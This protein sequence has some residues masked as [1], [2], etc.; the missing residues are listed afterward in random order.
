MA[1][2]ALR[3]KRR[4]ARADI[5]TVELPMLFRANFA[6]AEIEVLAASLENSLLAR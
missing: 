6:R 1:E 2:E 5:E 3:V 4:L